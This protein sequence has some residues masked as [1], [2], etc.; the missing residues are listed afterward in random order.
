MLSNQAWPNTRYTH[1]LESINEGWVPEHME[2]VY[3]AN[4]GVVLGI[5]PFSYSPGFSIHLVIY[6][7]IWA[8]LVRSCRNYEPKHQPPASVPLARRCRM[9]EANMVT[10]SKADTFVLGS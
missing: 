1:V 7:E 10:D 8:S 5:N 9:R 2:G 3:H 6:G 4:L